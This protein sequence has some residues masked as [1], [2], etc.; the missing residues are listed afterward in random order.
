M[1]PE[2]RI[3]TISYALRRFGI[4]L[5][6]IWVTATINFVTPRLAPG[7][8]V[9]AMLGRMQAQGAVVENGAAIVEGFRKEFGLDQPLYVQYLKYLWALVHF[10]MGYSLARFPGTVMDIIG[11]AI[12]YTLGLLSVSTVLTFSVGIL[13][14]ALLV[15][16]GTAR[17]AK[18]LIS[19]FMM[20]APIPYYLLA[21]V[22]MFLLSFTLHIFPNSGV[23][24]AG[25]LW[26]GGFD[27]GYILDLLYHATLPAL[28][29]II[30]GLGGWALGMRGM[31]VTV[32]GEDY[33][34]L[35]EAKGLRERRI[36]MRYAVRNAMLPQ[37]TGLAI[38]LGFIVSG[39]TIVELIFT[40]P[41]MG[42]QLY[43][44]II[45]S[46]YPVIQGITFFLVLSVAT[47]ILVIDLIY[48]L[49]D[50]R[51]TYARR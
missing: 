28:S 6:I 39:A 16:R 13:S 41:G 21:M 32:L 42:Y 24:S 19:I 7:D 50:P 2:E 4:F 11:T 14:G 23:V 17:A 27:V 18:A 30:A 36:F 9:Q 12:P 10:D 37:F 34:T 15:W 46:D 22:L 25:R 40:F 44:A 33:L 31:M 49:L 5:L 8:P 38:S 51:I 29:I 35:A 47:A 1:A 45:S 43:Q 48:P 20:L 3:M 26:Q